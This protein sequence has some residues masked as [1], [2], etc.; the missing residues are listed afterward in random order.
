MGVGLTRTGIE[1]PNVLPLALAVTSGMGCS[2]QPVARVV[3]AALRLPVGGGWKLREPSLL[4]LKC[5]DRHLKTVENLD[6]E[7]FEVGAPRAS[8]LTEIPGQISQIKWAC[9]NSSFD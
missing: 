5:W 1:R 9:A 3:E 2:P 4:R 6:F 7:I 8:E